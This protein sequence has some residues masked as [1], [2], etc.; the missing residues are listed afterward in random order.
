MENSELKWMEPIRLA[1]AIK[2]A[3]KFTYGDLAPHNIMCKRDGTITCIL[4][5]ETSGWF[6]EYWEYT[7]AHFAPW[8]HKSWVD[9]I[10]TITGDY[11]EQLTAER[12]AE[13]HFEPIPLGT[14]V[15]KY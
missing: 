8:A 13:V 10:G 4:D 5:W 11:P 7:K 9:Q 14:I 6:P 2:Y 1:H 3:S 15:F 12:K